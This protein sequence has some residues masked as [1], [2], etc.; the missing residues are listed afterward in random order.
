MDLSRRKGVAGLLVGVISHRKLPRAADLKN[1]RKTDVGEVSVAV[2]PVCRPGA[3][4]GVAVGGG[5]VVRAPHFP[6]SPVLLLPPRLR[7]MRLMSASLL[8]LPLFAS[9][10]LLTGGLEFGA[11][12]LIGVKFVAVVASY[13]AEIPPRCLYDDAVSRDTS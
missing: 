8:V 7:L 11:V 9:V 2:E 3:A 10:I 5:L 12:A 13:V 6:P 4:I 1:T